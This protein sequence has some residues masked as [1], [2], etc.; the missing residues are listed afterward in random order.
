M[1]LVRILLVLIFG[2]AALSPVM[3]ENAGLRNGDFKQ[4]VDGMPEGWQLIGHCKLLASGGRN[5]IPA[6]EVE[7]T[8]NEM[9]AA[10]QVI[11]FDQP[12]KGPFVVTAWI[13]CDEIAE[14]GDCGVWLDVMQAG[15]PAMWGQRGV[16]Q[17]ERKGWQQVRAEVHPVCPVSEVQL[18]LILRNTRGRVRY[19]DVRMDDIPVSITSLRAFSMGGRSYDVRGELS[20]STAWEIAAKQKDK[21][22]WK[23]SGESMR[24]AEKFATS[25][26]GPV[27]VELT[28]KSNSYTS[29]ASAVAQSRSIG[30]DI[31]WW[32]ADSFT[33]VFLDDLP[34]ERS[35]NKV[36]L[37]VAR[38]ERE[39]FQVCLRPFSKP[40]S[41]VRVK[42]SDLVKASG[43]S[44]KDSRIPS[45]A[46]EWYRVGY[47]WVEK[48]FAHQ[49][50]PRRA[51]SYWPDPLLP[52]N[53]FSVQAGEVQPLWFTLNISQNTQPGTYSGRIAIQADNQPAISVP[54]SVTV[55][56]A[57]VPAQ[58][59]MKT[60]FALMDGFMEKIYGTI[61]KPLRRAYTDYLLAHHLNPD[62]ISRTS[63][64]D[65]DD[66]SYANKRGLN[67]F[68]ILNVV[69]EPES[70]VVWTCFAPVAAYTPE[71]RKRFFQRLD[72]IMPQLE[73]RGLID[74]AYIYGFDERG[75][76]YIPII[77]DL[78][79]EIKRRYP[80]VHTLSTCWPP[81]ETD[82][83][84]LN[85]DWYVPLSSSYNHKLAQKVRENGGEM[86][87]YICMGPNY[88]YAN[89]LFENPL[90][91]AR[92]IWWQA[93]DYDVEGL[94]YWG[95]NIWDRPRND[96]PIPMN[97]GP[98]LDW[99]VT[100]TGQFDTLNGDGVLLY[101][102][103]NGP[104][105]SL[106]LENI[107]DGLEDIELLQQYRQRFSQKAVNELTKSVSVDMTHY[108]RNL[109]D[110]LSA[111][112]KMLKAL[113]VKSSSSKSTNDKKSNKKGKT[114]A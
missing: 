42:L 110:L 80:K 36:K 113:Q 98:R 64:P 47:I 66:L 53:K 72:E 35:I 109:N 92:L 87:W 34:P 33:R 11:H 4:Q 96:K 89:W 29:R 88:P 57:V 85:I 50:C 16:P 3:G 30:N 71:F 24:I 111:R 76:E 2:F 5:G 27:T 70:K 81:K 20:G 13:R 25:G 26:D 49:C 17:T 52:A 23:S 95:L 22:I 9:N 73:K 37:D 112:V 97:A 1:G 55:Y 44:S 15:G 6:V 99:S 41:N 62:D 8:G 94:L 21:I 58:G 38:N 43:K 46:I 39:S 63:F 114:K 32:V 108:S 86:W 77:R 7:S 90:I 68:N 105:G 104:I 40:L 54:V 91:E 51:A 107:C 83:L 75:P 84:S 10:L 61:S 82:P 103:E 18:Y 19:C 59:S 102:G 31:D 79:G 74:K 14:S 69:P 12:R 100:P 67:A 28:A 106:R 60:T 101:P 56:P 65:L 48:P 93:F 45:T 78:F